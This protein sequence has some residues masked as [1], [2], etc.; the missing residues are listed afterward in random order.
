MRTYLKRARKTLAIPF[1]IVPI[2]LAGCS[3]SVQS[4]VNR[5]TIPAKEEDIFLY[6]GIGASYLCNARAAGI[7]F[8][9]AVGIASATYV[10]VLEGK[11]GGVVAD[12]G[13][14]KLSRKQLFSGAEFQIITAA[15][16]F[17]P[18]QV[19]KDV[20]KKVKEL[21]EKQNVKRNK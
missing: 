9:K 10:Q 21:L 11:H 14:K 17:C 3:P 20:E 19:P 13:K 18:K 4:E 7:E 8:P 12:V 5:K 1:W 16:Q 2:L 6:R 15:L